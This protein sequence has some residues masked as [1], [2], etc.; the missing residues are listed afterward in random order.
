MERRT[1]KT[2]S[3]NIILLGL[4]SF[5]TDISSEMMM[6]ILPLFIVALG[7][8][9]LAVGLI[10]GL[11]DSL[12][13]ILKLISGYW[14]D[15]TGA[16]KPFVYSGYSTSAVSKFFFA[17][18]TTW[19]HILILRPLERVGKGLRTAPRDAIIADSIS[20]EQLGKGFGI[21]RAMDTAGAIIGSILALIFVWYFNLTF[22]AIFLI[23]AFI[24]LLAL[25]PLYWV[26]ERKKEKPEK[27]TLEIGLKGLSDSLKFFILAATIFALGNF[28]YMFFILRAQQSFTEE[29]AIIIPIFLYILYN[30]VYTIFSIPAGG[31][32]D[33]IG[34]KNV[35][36]FG[37][38][39]FGLTCIGFAF[40]QSFTSLIV[41]FSL[42]GLVLALIDG[43]QRAFV[44]DLSLEDLKGISLGTYHTAIGLVILPASIIAGVLWD[45][46][47]TMMFF[48]GAGMS[49][50]AVIFL[51]F[52]QKSQ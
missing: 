21:H 1:A 24:A 31:L 46:N 28:S 33:K 17:F 36:I 37:Y 44:S 47:P 26:K 49:F 5:L 23:A 7:G 34:R 18:A 6:P 25:I 4:V 51:A 39:L 40:F 50:I 48:Y 3:L 20:K 29:M 22:I 14:S 15:K 13:S 11:G 30:I 19:T 27:L 45:I 38:S 9:G 10:G 41:L 16:R 2:M 52:M 35:I 43:N 42:Y 12:S 8:A 32:S